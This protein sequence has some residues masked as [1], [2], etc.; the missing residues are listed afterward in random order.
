[1]PLHK[2]IDWKLNMLWNEK[3]FLVNEVIKY[4]Y[5]NTTY[6]GWC[7]IGYFRNGTDDLNTRFL[8][9]WPSHN[10]FLNPPF[11]QNVIHYGLVQHNINT[12]N[13]LVNDIKKHY[14]QNIKSQPTNKFSEICFSG[15]FF[16]SK[17]EMIDN[18]CL[19]YDQKLNYYFHNNFFIKDDQVIVMDIII[20]NPYLF[21]IHTE[22]N[23][24]NNWF[25]FQRI[26]L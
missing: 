3:P 15:G 20:N 5:F 24:F 4:K 25:M 17:P 2:I 14:K 10:K 19:L 1:M 7:D 18:Y 8:K 12:Y 11:N 16:V 6:Y 22:N 23:R 13:E 26:L 9:K 21:Y